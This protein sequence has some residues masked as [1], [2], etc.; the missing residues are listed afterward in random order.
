[1]SE[2]F[3]GGSLAVLYGTKAEYATRHGVSEKSVTE[4]LKL[5]LPEGAFQ[6]EDNRRQWRIPLDAPR[7]TPGQMAAARK[8]LEAGVGVGQELELARLA[9]APEVP[10]ASAAPTPL[11]QLDA[12]TGWISLEVAAAIL[13]VTK[14]AVRRTC[15]VEPFGRN[16]ALVVRHADV[17]A[18]FQGGSWEG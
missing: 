9:P 17:R 1:M 8:Q 13:G 15:T 7:P 5:G 14:A 12:Q 10:A 3:H 11:E 4:W 16:G 2:T 6:D 18:A